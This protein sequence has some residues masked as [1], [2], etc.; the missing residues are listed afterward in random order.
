[1]HV[2]KGQAL[3]Y[4]VAANILTFLTCTPL[5][6]GSVFQEISGYTSKQQLQAIKLYMTWPSEIFRTNFFN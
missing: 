1:M 4:V 3:G 5:V 6:V 2:K